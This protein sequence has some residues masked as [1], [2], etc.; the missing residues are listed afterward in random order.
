MQRYH[1][2]A[3][4]LLV[5]FA[6]GTV[7]SADWRQFRGP[8]GQGT[9]DEKGLPLRW[10]SQENIAWKVKLPGAGASCPIILGKRVY[11]TCYSGYGMDTKEPGKQEDLR[12][13]LLC[14][15]RGNGKMIWS[16]E[17]AP[18]LPE[19]R[20]TGEG[21]YHG[22]AASTPITDG[23]NLYVFFGKAGVFC[24]DLDGNQLW[25]VLVGKG[26]NGW[27]S[28]ASPIFYKDLLIVNASVEARALIALEKAS[29]KEVWQAPKVGSAWGTPVLVTTPEKSQELVLSMQGR[30]AG[31]DPDT[32]KELW[33]AAG[34]KGYVVPSVVAHDGIV[35][36]VGG[37]GTSLAIKSGGRGDVTQT[38]VLWRTSKGS[39]ASS[40]VYHDGT[41]YWVSES[42][43]VLH[44][45]D[46]AT[47]KSV[48]ER[49][50]PGVGRIWASPILAD[51]KLYFVSQFKG[52]YVVAA[53]PKFELLAHNVFEDD[54]SR[55]NASLAVSDGQLFLRN[56]QYLYCIGKR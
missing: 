7:F 2:A 27:G 4:V 28:G 21:A 41:L 36:A 15:D 45:Q 18:V 51:G 12:R 22:Y 31:F 34:H 5:L 9:S 30:V 32:G 10:S 8:T 1:R 42:G 48:A 43:G 56:D 20:Y 54:S 46:A 13:H 47:G 23:K 38:H 25:H 16:K 33:S 37:G 14:L 11:I 6:S 29:G 50:G 55:S 53:R 39:N 3:C 19:H 24:F 17:F 26:T 49:L 35:Y 44:I 40:P 52:T